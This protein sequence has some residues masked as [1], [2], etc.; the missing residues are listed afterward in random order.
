M[1][2]KLKNVKNYYR[3]ESIDH[4]YEKLYGILTY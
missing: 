3:R 2:E 1:N 4:E